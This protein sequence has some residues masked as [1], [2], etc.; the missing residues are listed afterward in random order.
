ML[1]ELY[2]ERLQEPDY[3]ESAAAFVREIRANNRVIS[4]ELPLDL[5]NEGGF[6]IRLKDVLVALQQEHASRR[7]APRSSDATAE[8]NEVVGDGV[9]ATAS[10]DRV[11]LTWEPSLQHH[12]EHIPSPSTS[13]SVPRTTALAVR[14]AGRDA[15]YVVLRSEVGVTIL[16]VRQDGVARTVALAVPFPVTAAA[17]GRGAEL[18]AL[19]LRSA[20]GQVSVIRTDEL[21]FG[22]VWR[23]DVGPL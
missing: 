7:H 2:R 12:R 18:G 16:R 8:V 19:T 17:L 4:N 1:N 11:T 13:W 9:R 22:E 3:G 20:A 15:A 6:R 10:A 21:Q 5:E 14:R 23:A